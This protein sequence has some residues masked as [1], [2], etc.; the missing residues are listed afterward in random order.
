MMG[1]GGKFNGLSKNTWINIFLRIPTDDDPIINA[2]QQF[3]E[4]SFSI[5]EHLPAFEKFV[6]R[7]Y[8]STSIET[9][10]ELRWELF[11]CK[12]KEAEKLPP[13]RGALIPHI[14]RANYFAS[15]CKGYRSSNPTLADTS[16]GYDRIGD[17]LVPI[18]SLELPAPEYLLELVKCGCKAGCT[19]TSKCS[20][21]SNGFD[22]IPQCKC[23]DC[24]NV[25]DYNVMD[26]L[27]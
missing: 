1:G 15:V 21:V 27:D 22:C 5:D 16:G 8:G 6:C 18:M 17:T 3:G 20:C 11:R 13:T 26:D 4:T 23:S 12:E 25:K 19:P 10:S 14:Q 24:Q 2:M 9:V 7:A